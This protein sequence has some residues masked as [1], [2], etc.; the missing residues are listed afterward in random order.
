MFAVLGL[1]VSVTA[2]DEPF[3]I[4]L[5]VMLE[6]VARVR[7]LP[8]NCNTGSVAEAA[9]PADTVPKTTR[10]VLPNAAEFPNLTVPALSWSVPAYAALEPLIVK[11]SVLVLVIL[12]KPAPKVVAREPEVA[13]SEPEAIVPPVSEPPARTTFPNAKLPPLSPRLPPTW[14]VPVVESEA[15]DNN[16]A[17]TPL[18]MSNSGVRTGALTCNVK[19]PEPLEA[20][21]EVPAFTVPSRVIDAP[22]VG[23]SR[24]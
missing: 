23:W 10:P 1:N 11:I 3:S 13:A 2:I 7:S 4:A 20:M 18:W 21:T 24:I 15:P 12:P 22:P 5:P 8:A 17:L 14:S 16:V 19:A 9:A 6:S